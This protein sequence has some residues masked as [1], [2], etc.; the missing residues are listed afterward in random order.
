MFLYPTLLLALFSGW[1]H[2][3]NPEEM[4]K[5]DNAV[6]EVIRGDKLPTAVRLAFHDCVGGCDGCLN[7]N[8]AD[9]AGF[10]DLMEALEK[11]YQAK[12][13]GD[14][15]SR[16]DFW[17]YGSIYAIEKT[18]ELANENC[19]TNDCHVPKPN[20]KFQYGRIDCPSSPYSEEHLLYPSPNF[21]YQGVVS[22]FE[23]EFGFTA[24]ETVAL[25]GVHTLGKASRNNSGFMGK[26]V[27][28]EE[29]MFSN[30]YYKLLKDAMWFQ[31][32]LTPD[33]EAHFQWNAPR[34]G[35]ML[36]SDMAIYKDM[37]LNDAGE[38][39]CN[40]T[41]CPLSQGASLVQIY[42]DSNAAWIEDFA[43]VYSKMISH[44]DFTL[45]NLVEDTISSED[46]SP[47]DKPRVPKST[48]KENSTLSSSSPSSSSAQH[49]FIAYT[50][51][52]TLFIINYV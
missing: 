23:T 41:T 15:I 28:N 9:N 24:N 44:G 35:F 29:L 49:F 52:V 51:L 16:A 18:V 11:V 47:L 21:D 32:N 36:N 19:F 25:M 48:T 38:S 39:S 6:K 10:N 5:V 22:Y 4:K 37:K 20:L 1:T 42:S 43:A 27:E 26:W 46:K 7:V 3:L 14:I 34:K 40:Y 12:K 2:A 8:D 17:V 30:S 31:V 45:S 13:L 33:K 50:L